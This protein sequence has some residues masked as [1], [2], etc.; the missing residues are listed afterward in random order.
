MA[1][2][3]LQEQGC[4]VIGIT[5]QLWGKDVCVSSG[6]RLCC[7]VRDT[8][9]AKAVAKTSTQTFSARSL[10]WA[11]LLFPIIRSSTATSGLGLKRCG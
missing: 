2:A 9:D 3:L 11:T 4:E 10:R 6:S 7:S 8:M 5:L 1:A